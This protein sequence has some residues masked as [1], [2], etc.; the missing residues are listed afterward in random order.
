MA[1]IAKWMPA[2]MVAGILYIPADVSAQQILST[3]E[4]RAEVLLRHSLHWRT[5]RGSR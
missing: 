3:R 1:K 2:M 4:R 5:A